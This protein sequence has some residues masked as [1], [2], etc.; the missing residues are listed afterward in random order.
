ML[1]P[2]P[3]L[4]AGLLL[5]ALPLLAT[6]RTAPDTAPPAAPFQKVSELV[7]LPDFLPGLGTLYV[8]PARLPA[9]PFLGYDHDGKLS[10]TIYMT[11]LEDLEGGSAFNDLAVGSNSVTSVDIYYNAG[12]PGVEK[13]HVHVVLYHDTDAKARL[14]E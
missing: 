12:H 4:A 13:P 7:T 6:A 8:D 11:P 3:L 1:R 2:M 14:A 9:G 10:A 5:G